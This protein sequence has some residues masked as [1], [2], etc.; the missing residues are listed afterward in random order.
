MQGKGKYLVSAIFFI[1]RD[2]D[3]HPECGISGDLWISSRA[4]HHKTHNGW[5][6][7]CVDHLQSTKHPF[8]DRYLTLHP[9]HCSIQWV[10]K[11]HMRQIFAKD[12]WTQGYIQALGHPSLREL[13]QRENIK[14]IVRTPY[15][16]LKTAQIIEFLC[17]LLPSFTGNAMEQYTPPN[18]QTGP[19][20]Y[21]L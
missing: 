6:V 19:G 9:A 16:S 5:T 14:E 3:P 10:K 18:A 7:S 17:T 13:S 15:K 8:L 12:K 20:K 4:I 1:L 21:D 2:Q 11:S